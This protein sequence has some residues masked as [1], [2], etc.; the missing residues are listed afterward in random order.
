MLEFLGTIFGI[1]L[2][3][4]IFGGMLAVAV[5]GFMAS[6]KAVKKQMSNRRTAH[7]PAEASLHSPAVQSR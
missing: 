4:I 5:Y 2:A 3:L 1:L 6:E 7:R